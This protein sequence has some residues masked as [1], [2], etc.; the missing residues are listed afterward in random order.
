MNKETKEVIVNG[1]LE[2]LSILTDEIIS[3]VQSRNDVDNVVEMLSE[4]FGIEI[5]EATC[6]RK[7]PIPPK[8]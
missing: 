5:S 6:K 7:K 8:R 3:C 4:Q 2:Q 1:D